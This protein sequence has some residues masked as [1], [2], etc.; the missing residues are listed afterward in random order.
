VTITVLIQPLADTRK[1][2][3]IAKE[4]INIHTGAHRSIQQLCSL[5]FHLRQNYDCTHPVVVHS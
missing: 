4:M 5:L 3:S 1:K 2:A